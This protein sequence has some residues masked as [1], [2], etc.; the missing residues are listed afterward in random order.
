MPGWPDF[1]CSTASIASVLIVLIASRIRSALGGAGGMARRLLGG[2]LRGACREGLLEVGDERTHHLVVVRL[3]RLLP[4]HDVLHV[5][6][7]R[8]SRD[9]PTPVDEAE[10]RGDGPADLE[11]L[12]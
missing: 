11:D 9:Q 8:R 7:V 6:R 3:G 4:H 10:G 5:A 2:R 1:A 12:R